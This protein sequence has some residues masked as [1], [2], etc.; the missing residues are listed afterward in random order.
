MY[1][2]VVRDDPLHPTEKKKKAKARHPI[3]KAEVINTK[4]RV[5]NYPERKREKKAKRTQLVT[6]TK[7]DMISY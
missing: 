6:A 5:L 3:H 1:L 4:F 2:K 7:F